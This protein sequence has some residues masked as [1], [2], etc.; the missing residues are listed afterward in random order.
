MHHR[1]IFT[2]LKLKE[3]DTAFSILIVIV[4]VIVIPVYF[5]EIINIQ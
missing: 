3:L 4:R 1:Q 5:S 2:S